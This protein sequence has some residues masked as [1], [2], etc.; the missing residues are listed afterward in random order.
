[1][2]NE[3]TTTTPTPEK[4]TI[5]F[6]HYETKVVREV[7]EPDKLQQF[8][9][10]FITAFMTSEEHYED[11]P[12][13]RE[14]VKEVLS[15]LAA[16]NVGLALAD[17]QIKAFPKVRVEFVKKYFSQFAPKEKARK[18]TKPEKLDMWNL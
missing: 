17:L 3:A 13:Y 8:S 10:D 12:W 9:R 2:D 4:K 5:Q 1:M 6:T 18:A 14:M 7:A 15:K 16:E 11:L